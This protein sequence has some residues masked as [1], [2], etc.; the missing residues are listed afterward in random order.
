[1]QWLTNK[2]DGDFSRK[3]F[4]NFKGKWYFQRRLGDQ[5]SMKGIACFKPL[6][7]SLLHYQETGIVTWYTPSRSLPAYRSYGYQYTKGMLQVYFLENNQP[8]RLFY[9][10]RLGISP[11]TSQLLYATGHHVCSQDIYSAYYLF[12]SITQFSLTY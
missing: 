9:T 1:M 2:V 11:A 4:N 7:S 12:Q 10:L 8:H 5:A 3:V 6:N